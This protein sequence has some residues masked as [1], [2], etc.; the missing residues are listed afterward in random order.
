MN[1]YNLRYGKYMNR[2]VFHFAKYMN[3]MAFGDSA[4][5]PYLNP[6]QV[7]PPPPQ[8][9]THTHLAKRP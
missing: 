5:C 3:V 2:S 9:H 6:W 4:A 7:T 8:T 1:W